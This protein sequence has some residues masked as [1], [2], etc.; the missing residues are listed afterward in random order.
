MSDFPRR[1]SERAARAGAI[2]TLAGLLVACAGYNPGPR[3]T[4]GAATGAVADQRFQLVGNL[5]GG[6]SQTRHGI[7]REIEQPGMAGHVDRRF[8]KVSPVVFP[9]NLSCKHISMRIYE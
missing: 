8:Q 6:H 3:A 7:A 9:C 1:L 5:G 4:L 2:I